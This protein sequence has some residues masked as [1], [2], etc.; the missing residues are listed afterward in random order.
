MRETGVIIVCKL[1]VSQRQRQRDK[2]YFADPNFLLLSET[3]ESH[4]ETALL[5]H[6]DRPYV[7]GDTPAIRYLNLINFAHLNLLASTSAMDASSQPELKSSKQIKNVPFT[8]AQ[9]VWSNENR[10]GTV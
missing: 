1:S 7:V 8:P 10:V 2:S 3:Y 4:E 6:V 5:V 9:I